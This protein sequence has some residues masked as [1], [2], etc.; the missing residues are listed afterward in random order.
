MANKASKFEQAGGVHCRFNLLEPRGQVGWQGLADRLL[1]RRKILAHCNPTKL[2]AIC[3]V[4]LQ[5]GQAVAEGKRDVSRRLISRRCAS[6]TLCQVVSGGI[7][8][9]QRFARVSCRQL[10][11]GLDSA[12][13]GR[14]RASLISRQPV[15]KADAD[16]SYREQVDRLELRTKEAAFKLKYGDAIR[17]EARKGG[18]RQ[19][20]SKGS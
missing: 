14:R 9:L 6:G 17:G 11:D 13:L 19:I 20:R 16:A 1:G 4:S 15:S 3:G 5:F 12:D 10:A 8:H 7:R 2:A 18:A